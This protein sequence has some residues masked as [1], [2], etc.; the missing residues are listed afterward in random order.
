MIK[1]PPRPST[2]FN[3]VRRT[4]ALRAAVSANYGVVA[5]SRPSTRSP[6]SNVNRTAGLDQESHTA[7]PRGF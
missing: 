4:G 6:L 1:A 5:V 3:P 2:N 7:R